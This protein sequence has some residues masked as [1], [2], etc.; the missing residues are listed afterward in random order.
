MGCRMEPI[1]STA[2][3]AA[4]LVYFRTAPSSPAGVQATDKYLT[5]DSANNLLSRPCH[6]TSVLLNGTNDTVADI[7]RV[8][9][10]IL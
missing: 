10:H 2:K 7:V 4:V 5:A 9:G 6:L 3:A 8:E 1:L